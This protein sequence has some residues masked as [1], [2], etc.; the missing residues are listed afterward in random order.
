[1]YNQEK[2]VKINCDG[3]VH[4]II[5][6]LKQ[7]PPDAKLTISGDNLFYIHCEQDDSLVN[8]DTESLDENYPDGFNNCQ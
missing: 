6:L 3:T 1:M 4:S 5:S 2:C 8:L 7:Y